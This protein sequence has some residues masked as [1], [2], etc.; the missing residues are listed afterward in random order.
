MNNITQ[1]EAIEYYIEELS[2]LVNRYKNALYNNSSDLRFKDFDKFKE[3]A[4]IDLE[5]I[6]DG[7]KYH[8]TED[9]E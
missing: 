7:I 8:K 5:D 2:I 4:L 9:F 6:I 1:T 3:I